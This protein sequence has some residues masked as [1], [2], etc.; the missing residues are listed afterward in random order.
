MRAA[1]VGD[2]ADDALDSDA[3]K[4]LQEVA[5]PSLSSRISSSERELLLN[6]LRREISSELQLRRVDRERGCHAE[7]TEYPTKG[8][9]ELQKEIHLQ[10]EEL[11]TVLRE[12]Y[13]SSRADPT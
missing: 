1:K 12:I 10:T 6:E 7:P 5:R 4:N 2:A 8:I 9:E 13:T 3:E 11:S